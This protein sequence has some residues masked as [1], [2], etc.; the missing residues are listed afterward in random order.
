MKGSQCR[1]QAE[2]ISETERQ[3]KKNATRNC[4]LDSTFSLEEEG[5]IKLET[6][7]SHQAGVSQQQNNNPAVSRQMVHTTEAAWMEEIQLLAGWTVMLQHR[8]ISAFL[9]FTNTPSLFHTLSL[10]NTHTHI[11]GCHQYTCAHAFSVSVL[12]CNSFSHIHQH[13]FIILYL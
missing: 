1:R 5:I 7:S 11:H 12:L 13:I 3:G 10:I 9:C 6:I 2:L 4:S 8:L